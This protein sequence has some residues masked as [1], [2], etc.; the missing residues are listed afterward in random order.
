MRF[1]LL[2]VSLISAALLAGCQSAP[3]KSP[4]EYRFAKEGDQTLC[5]QTEPAGE[6]SLALMVRTA[7][8]EKGYQVRNVTDFSDSD[9]RRCVK[10]TVQTDGWSDSR[11]KSASL[12]YVRDAAGIRHKVTADGF[13]T[14]RVLGTP[15]DDQSMIIWSLVDRLFP[16][17]MPWKDE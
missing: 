10:F 4:Y 12:E 11:I 9:C 3:Q 7:L 8:E 2:T 15:S 6:V 5:L 14:D 17:P 13:S 1:K 16:D